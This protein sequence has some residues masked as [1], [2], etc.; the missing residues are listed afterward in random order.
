MEH[1]IRHIRMLVEHW[2]FLMMIINGLIVLMKQ[3]Y[4]QVEHSCDN[5]SSPYFGTMK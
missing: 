3:L 1:Y 4:G 2:A 5:Y